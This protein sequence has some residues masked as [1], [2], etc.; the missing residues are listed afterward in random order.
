MKTVRQQPH[1]PAPFSAEPDPTDSKRVTEDVASAK[2]QL[3]LA[4]NRFPCQ[5]SAIAV[6][7]FN[8]GNGVWKPTVS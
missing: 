5:S 4:F 6:M 2:N 3:C 1:E 7:L 8:A